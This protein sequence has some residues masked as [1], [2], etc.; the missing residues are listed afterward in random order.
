MLLARVHVLGPDATELVRLAAV[1]G[2]WVADADLH[3]ASVLPPERYAPAVREAVDVGVLVV[4]GADYAFRHSLMCEAVLAQLLPIERRLLH[5]Q[6]AHALA[7]RTAD[8]VVTAV[9]VS[10]HWEAAGMPGRAAEW[11]LRAARK[12][13]AVNAFAEAW[14]HFQRAL[15]FGRDERGPDHLQL[16]LEAAGAARLGGDPA[17]A[18]ALIEEALRTEPADDAV[19]RRSGAPRLL[20]VGGGAHDR[21][22]WPRT[23]RRPRRSAATSRRCTRRCGVPRPGPR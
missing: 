9:A 2:L 13:R 16:V 15:Q 17:A 7:G 6:A 14:G 8:D 10:V 18:A 11:C 19:R 4:E 12:A 20:P 22:A 1:F 23:R 21:R 5:E 3:S